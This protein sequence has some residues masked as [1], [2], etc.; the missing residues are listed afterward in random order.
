MTQEQKRRPENT[1]TWK[2]G[3]GKSIGHQQAVCLLIQDG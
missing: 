2:I 1:K 3:E